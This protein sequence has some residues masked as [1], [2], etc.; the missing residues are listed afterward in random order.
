MKICLC[1][2][3]LLTFR[4][5]GISQEPAKT[6][7]QALNE[8]I[9]NTQKFDQKKEIRLNKLSQNLSLGNNDSL[10]AQYLRLFEEYSAYN[11]DSAYYYAVRMHAAASALGDGPRIAYS[12]IKLSFILLSSGMFKEVFASLDTVST[13]GLTTPQVAEYY[14]LLTRYNYDLADYSQ[15]NIYAPKYVIAANR[16]IDSALAYYRR[17]SFEWLYYSGLKYIHS[18]NDDSA[19]VYLSGLLN[20]QRLSEHQT[21]IVASTFSD[22]F[23]RSHEN[24]KAKALLSRAAIGDIRS[25]TKETSAIFHLAELLFK[26]GDIK[27][28]SLYIHKAA[29]DA[30]FYGARQRMTELS[31][32]LPLIEGE[33][34]DAAEAEKKRISIYATCITLLMVLLVALTFVVVRQVKKLQIQQKEI[35][36][37][38]A[39]LQ[40]FL[41]EKDGLLREKEWLLKEVNH[42]VKNNLQIVMSLLNTQSEYLENEALV[43]IKDS[44]HRVYAMS[45]IHQKLYQLDNVKTIDMSVYIHELVKYLRES[46]GTRLRILFRLNIAEVELD[47]SKA[48][49]LGLILNEAITNSIKYAFPDDGDGV[50]DIAVLATPENRISLTVA[51]NGI[52]LPA[53]FDSGRDGSL[54]MKLMQG[55]SRDLNAQFT[56]E[57]NHGTVIKLKFSHTS[58]GNGLITK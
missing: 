39:S 41:T 21:A 54:G 53:G 10:Y 22:I 1:C 49:P 26:E 48:V 23:I 36:T 43:A 31:A 24:E 47:V 18:G 40:A 51:D 38:N 12:R 28:A 56:V 16:Y 30:S 27:D 19:A 8:T 13:T 29:S 25:S 14:A 34:V 17:R 35:T 33:N 32:V 7:L 37:K 3:Y 58:S 4:L 9:L 46:F 57:S 6:T 5:M 20:D 42:R 2:L 45:L 50:V 55:L 52:G 11:Y 15:D 44:K